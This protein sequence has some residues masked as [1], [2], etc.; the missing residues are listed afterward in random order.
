MLITVTG[1]HMDVGQSLRQHAETT[2]SEAIAKYFDRA[3]EA[4][5][6]FSKQNSNFHADITA[7]V[8]RG[9]LV[10]GSDQAGDAYGAF[11]A[12]CEHV[13]KRLRRH[14]RRLRGL[15]RQASQDAAS[16][17]AQQ[18]VLQDHADESHD[19]STEP[20]AVP[21]P[22]VVAEMTTELPTITV[23]EAVMRLDLGE[24]SA[25]MFRNS[26][27]GGL[28]MVY[29]RRDGHIGWVDPQGMSEAAR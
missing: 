19:P 14:K 8:G 25:M 21:E 20:S 16:F 24:Q 27:H 13:A 2:L 29:R 28:N 18:Y 6:V 7:H 4:H 26:A 12:A 23:S 9:M 22:V 15:S 3:I 11:N 17:E 5:V 1:R 10:Q